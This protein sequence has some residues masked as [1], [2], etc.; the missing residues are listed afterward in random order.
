METVSTCEFQSSEDDYWGSRVRKFVKH[1][2]DMEGSLALQ[3]AINTDSAAWGIFAALLMTVG[4]SGLFIGNTNFNENNSQNDF[5][6]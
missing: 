3:D 1:E 4:F 5:A 2:E 6:Q